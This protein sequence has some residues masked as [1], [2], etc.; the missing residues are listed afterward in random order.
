VTVTA[1]GIFHIEWKVYVGI[2]VSQWIVQQTN[3]ITNPDIC[4]TLR[5]CFFN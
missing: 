3:L 2:T 1:S 5:W 4:Y